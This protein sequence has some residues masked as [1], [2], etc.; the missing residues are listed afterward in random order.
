MSTVPETIIARHAGMRVL[1][2]SLMT[3]MAAG[4]SGETL[5]HAHTLAQAAGR[6]RA[7]PVRAARRD[8]ARRCR[9]ERDDHATAAIRSTPHA[10]R[11]AAW[12]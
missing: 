2:L 5:S 8:R 6:R 7:T 12:T 1:A 11:C 9:S 4:L 3:N 10:P